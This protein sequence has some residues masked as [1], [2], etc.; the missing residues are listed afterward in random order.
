GQTGA[1]LELAPGEPT[2]NLYKMLREGLLYGV[3]TALGEARKTGHPARKEGIR[4][5]TNGHHQTV[6][7]EVIPL[8]AFS[9]ERSYLVLFES[10]HA[11]A[12]AS[13]A[14]DMRRNGGRRERPA[15]ARR[16]ESHE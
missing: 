7:V 5:K 14:P 11:E 1:F 6:D 12:S 13:T 15:A 8:G 3:R 2:L 9:T 10:A 16:A 4:L